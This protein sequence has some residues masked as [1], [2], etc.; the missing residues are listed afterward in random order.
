MASLLFKPTLVLGLLAA[1]SLAI[2]H[3]GPVATSAPT[4]RA[5]TDADST[6]LSCWDALSDGQVFQATNAKWDIL[7]ATDY[8]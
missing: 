7:C 5:T 8:A 2:P 1:H 6:D 4:K 3:P